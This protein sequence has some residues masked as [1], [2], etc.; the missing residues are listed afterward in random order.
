MCLCW[1]FRKYRNVTNWAE[2]ICICFWAFIWSIN[3]KGARIHKTEFERGAPVVGRLLTSLAHSSF[4]L[5]WYEFYK[6]LVSLWMHLW[7]FCISFCAFLFLSSEPLNMHTAEHRN[8]VHHEPYIK[9]LL[10]ILQYSS[11][12]H[13]S[14]MSR[15]H[16]ERHKKTWFSRISLLVL[17]IQN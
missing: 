10:W 11:C 2:K 15:T 1:N 13:V 6:F 12:F 4:Q 8:S 5:T 16:F 14:R 7:T 17:F 9:H 3:R